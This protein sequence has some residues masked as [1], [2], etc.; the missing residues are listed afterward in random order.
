METIKV[1]VKGIRLYANDESVNIILTLEDAIPGIAKVNGEYVEQDVDTISMY[2]SKLTAQLC[3][4]NDDIA[5]YRA[6][7]DTAF[8]QRALGVILFKAK[9]TLARTRYEA[10]DVI[11]T[12]EETGET[13]TA[14]RTMFTTDIVGVKLNEKAEQL[15]QNAITL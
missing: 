13:I 11:S 7:R 15:L 12:D 9:L 2:R 8:D 1:T 5:W 6:C 4:V 3:D 10:G 14:P